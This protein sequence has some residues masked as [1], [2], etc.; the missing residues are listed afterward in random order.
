MKKQ[1][2]ISQYFLQ[3]PD[4]SLDQASID[5]KIP[6]STIQGIVANEFEESRH[7]Y[8]VPSLACENKFYV[9]NGIN[10]RVLYTNYK[11]EVK[12]WEIFNVKE[13]K[14]I[15]NKGFKILDHQKLWKKK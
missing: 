15:R 5:L 7:I 10:E 1:K 4:S 13:K 3:N 9:F 2:V 12:N 11:N 14:E 6:K 8:I